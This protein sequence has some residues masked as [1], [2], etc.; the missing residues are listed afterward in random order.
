M[1]FQSHRISIP[2]YTGLSVQQALIG[3]GSKRLTVL[4]PGVGYFVDAPL[5]YYLREV[6]WQHDDDVLSVQYGF[7]VAQTDYQAEHQA[8]I[9]EESQNTIEEA[10]KHGGYEELFL[11]G[12]SLGTPMA[13][14]FANH[15]PQA[16]KVILLTPIQ[17]CHQLI[18]KTDTLAIIGTGDSRY[19]TELA[20]DSPLVKWQVYEG[21]NHS[22]EMPDDYQT[23]LQ[24]LSEIM[25]ACESFLY[26]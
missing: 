7:Q 4:L 22:L 3:E 24:K 20:Q 11:V 16:K 13:A 12:K 21:L 19:S 9:T 18:Q 2:S 5:L 8:S 25:K 17:N 1:S 15:F 10:L 26:P 6:A 23:S 14:L